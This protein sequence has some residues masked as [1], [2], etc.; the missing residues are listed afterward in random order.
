MLEN[1]VEEGV[2]GEE[3]NAL[4]IGSEEDED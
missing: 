3:D 1:E 4:V 2:E